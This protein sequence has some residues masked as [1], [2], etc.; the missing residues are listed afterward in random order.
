MASASARPGCCAPRCAPGTWARPPAAASTNIPPE[1]IQE[2][3][4]MSERQFVKTSLEERVAILTIDHPPVNALNQPT[5][6]EL[7][8]AVDELIANPEVKAVVV[9]GAG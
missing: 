3:T 5:L 1:P 8:E 9:T 2:P 4:R 6:V 7:N